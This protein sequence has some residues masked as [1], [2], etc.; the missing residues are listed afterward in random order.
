MRLMQKYDKD[1]GVVGVT[2]LERWPI[3][4]AAVDF[5]SATETAGSIDSLKK[6]PLLVAKR[7]LRE[8]LVVLARATLLSCT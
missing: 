4:S 7:R 1:E 6:Q 8:D 3:G 5:L 2:D